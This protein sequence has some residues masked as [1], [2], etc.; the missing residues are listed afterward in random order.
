M[1]LFKGPAH[2]I[3]MDLSSKIVKHSAEGG[4]SKDI[5]AARNSFYHISKPVIE[6]QDRIGHSDDDFYLTFCPMARDN[7]G[8]YWIQEV[9]T[10]Y[11]SFYGAVML[12]C[13]SIEKKL[14]SAG[15]E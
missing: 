11:N 9:D 10:V 3:W 13:G 5:D 14:P 12:R 8:A 6:L 15:V 2:E 4:R 1:T 7:T